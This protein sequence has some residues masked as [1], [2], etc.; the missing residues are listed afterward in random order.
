MVGREKARDEEESSG[1]REIVDEKIK[2][3]FCKDV[4]RTL[5]FIPSEMGSYL[6]VLSRSMTG[7]HLC[8]EVIA[9]R[10]Y[11]ENGLKGRA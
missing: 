9:F 1:V 11:L 8:F 5:A 6:R 2:L 7:S 3:D 10:Y 4:Q